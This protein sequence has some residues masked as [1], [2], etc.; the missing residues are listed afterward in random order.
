MALLVKSFVPQTIRSTK[1]YEGVFREYPVR[2][3]EFEEHIDVEYSVPVS[4]HT[5]D[6]GA[7]RSFSRAFPKTVPLTKETFQ[8]L[9]LLQGEMSKT[10]NRP[11]TFANTEPAL[12]NCVLEWF[13]QNDLLSTPDW[14]W[15]IKINL[16]PQGEEIDDQLSSELKEHWAT[17]TN[18]HW[19]NSYPTVLSFTPTSPRTVPVNDGCLMLEHRNSI[20]TQTIQRLV[21]KMTERM[22]SLDEQHIVWYMQGI[23]A[24]ESCINWSNQGHRRIFITAPDLEERALFQRC[25][26]RCGVESVSSKPIRGLIISGRSNLERV[27][28]LG[29]M[30]LHPKK[31]KK[32]SQM[33]ASYQ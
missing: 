14:K 8:A 17:V 10:H 4:N 6:T 20:L 9:G 32:F 15:Y 21:K 27:H 13:E 30:N 7:L 11:L 2:V 31:H 25:L 3:H 22:P 5:G 33:L 24:A 18:V 16:P 28:E 1:R 23:I 26:E 29:L 12:I 19:D